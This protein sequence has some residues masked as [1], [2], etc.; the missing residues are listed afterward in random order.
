MNA[1]PLS[2]QL[3]ALTVQYPNG[4]RAVNQLSLTVVP[5]EVFGLVGPNGAGKSSL[6]KC[7]A[8]LITPVAG[9]VRCGDRVV[10]GDAR[11]TAAF[12]RLMPD[13]LGVYNDLSAAEYLEFF[14]RA[15][16]VSAA[17]RVAAINV[18]VERLELGPWLGHEVETLSAGWQRRLALARVLLA[19]AP[20]VLLDEPAAGLDVSARSSLLK[21]VRGIAA[22]DRTVIITSHILPELEQLA[23][24]FGIIEHGA[25]L[26]VADS[27]VFFTPADLARGF[28]RATWRVSCSD[29]AKA[30]AVLGAERATVAAEPDAILVHVADRDAAAAAVAELVAAGVKVYSFQP[31]TTNLAELTLKTLG[32]ES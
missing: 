16:G 23:D 28:G 17:E 19:D 7:A 32:H 25:W 14:A 10:T 12:V 3:D 27:R 4:T 8:G 20:I 5:G 29:P 11:A 1:T 31:Q 26:P 21:I 22:E 24:R 9:A 13:P 30:C 15:L 2:L 6:L 18:A